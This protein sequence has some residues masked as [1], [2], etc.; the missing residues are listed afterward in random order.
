MEAKLGSASMPIELED[1][2]QIT[3][4][5]STPLTSTRLTSTD[6]SSI[7][8]STGRSSL[9]EI[10]L[11]DL[12]EDEDDKSGHSPVNQVIELDLLE[13]EVDF[14][15]IFGDEPGNHSNVQREPKPQR[16]PRKPRAVE[17]PYRNPRVVYPL[18]SRESCDHNGMRLRP[19]K[20]VELKDGDFLRISH[21]IRNIETGQATLR[22]HRLQ[23]VRDLN[24][25]L[26]KKLNEVC[27]CYEVDLDDPRE[28]QE[29]GAVEASLHQITRLRSVRYTNQ[30]FPLCR[31]VSISDF[32]DQ[33]TAAA[34]GGLTVRW[35]STCTYASA[36]ERHQNFHKG[37]TL[38]HIRAEE[39]P[40]LY[41]VPD[42][43][44]R[45]EWRGETVPGGAYRPAIGEYEAIELPEDEPSI[46]VE[47]GSD[48]LEAE[49]DVI[50]LCSPRLES[51]Y[52]PF[53]P[54]VEK[55]KRKHDTLEANYEPHPKR[56]EVRV[57]ATRP[58]QT[59]SPSLS[60]RPTMSP[61]SSD[62]STPPPLGSLLSLNSSPIH[63]LRSPNQ[64]LTY[65]DAF[66]GAGGTTRGAL[67]AGLHIKWG[68]DFNPT[69]CLTW[70]ANFPQARCFAIRSDEFVSLA[71]CSATPDIMKVDILHLSPP[72]QF[73]S[74]AHTKEGP[75][76]E[77]NVAS[78]FAVR[79][80]IEVARPRVVTLEQTFGIAALRFRFYF[81]A[82][83]QMFTALDFSIRWVV[84]PLSQWGLPQ[85]RNRLIIIAS[86]PG[87][88][89]PR[90]PAATH[91]QDCPPLLPLV[92]VNAT[93]ARIPADALDHDPSAVRYAPHRVQAPWDGDK[94][95]G[96]ITTH[97]ACRH[98]SGERDFTLREYATLQGFPINHLFLGT[99]RKKQIGNAVPPCVAKVLFESIK[100]DLDAADGVVGEEPEV[101]S[102]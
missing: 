34:E 13:D 22:G 44:R 99:Y 2:D 24:G 20:T 59:R 15:E 6:R 97:G 5:T 67:Q 45:F 49:D 36:A 3:L 88:C 50:W 53:S 58:H 32:A 54:A 56:H 64:K 29:Q 39:T 9:K 80:V 74:P 89:L 87:E 61:L 66:C 73:F 85:R 37:R 17:Y 42:I 47:I 40:G 92:S 25:M 70:R 102:D 96:T 41:A 95:T 90:M 19:G 82:L 75:D 101:I 69:P 55:G 60:P 27:L 16:P 8:A 81:N 63:V 48:N 35:K 57:D 71:R 26:E 10:I 72:C 76:D 77:M 100:R 91:G 23:R 46:S 11:V 98:P 31:N 94:I 33:N 52:L 38:E 79:A 14:T 51:M 84:V 28:P 93:L 65:G 83:I 43:I 30:P 18:S 62:L 78:L 7:S 12:D 21:I 68:F 4:R 1:D 86:C